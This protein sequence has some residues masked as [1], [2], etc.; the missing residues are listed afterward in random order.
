[1]MGVRNFLSFFFFLFCQIAWE[2]ELLQ[3]EIEPMSPAV[4]AQ[5]PNQPP[6]HREVWE[7]GIS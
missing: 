5:S 6:D 3:P 4:K 7:R 2:V 1:M